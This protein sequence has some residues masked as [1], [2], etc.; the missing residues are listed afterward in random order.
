MPDSRFETKLEKILST[1]NKFKNINPEETVLT[2]DQLL[3]AV[4][5]KGNWRKT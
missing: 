4:R 5:I 1:M 2:E 3:N